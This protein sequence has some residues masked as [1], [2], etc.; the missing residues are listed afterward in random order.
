MSDNNF[1][2]EES[3]KKESKILKTFYSIIDGSFLTKAR[4]IDLMPF[5]FYLVGLAI[6]LIFNSYYAEKRIKA[7][8]ELR[9]ELVEL[10]IK[11]IT[12]K[13]ELM[14]ITNQSEIARKLKDKG[15]AEST[16][17][18]KRIEKP[19]RKKSFLLNITD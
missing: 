12:T 16:V 1:K 11:Y 7:K 5:F 6:V 9:S 17:P 13:S 3:K 19:E 2:K 14:F 10:R 18:P 15:L 4:M 8:E